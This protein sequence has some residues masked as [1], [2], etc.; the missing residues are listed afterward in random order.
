MSGRLRV[1]ALISGRGSN[2]AALVEAALASD[3]PASITLVL[4]NKLDA[5]GLDFA[6]EAGVAAEA[7]DSKLYADHDAFEAALQA[8]LEAHDIEF[9]CLAGFMR[10]LGP[11]LRRA[12]ARAHAQQSS[13]AAARVARHAYA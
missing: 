4:S 9:I 6:R 11:R 12:L 1:A 5:P 10:V 3:F 2:M 7:V 13:L 8:R